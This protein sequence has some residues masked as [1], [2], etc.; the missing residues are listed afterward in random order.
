MYTGV[1]SG[2]GIAQ[3]LAVLNQMTILPAVIAGSDFFSIGNG[4]SLPI[5]QGGSVSYRYGEMNVETVRKAFSA[6]PIDDE[7]AGEN[8]VATMAMSAAYPDGMNPGMDMDANE[9]LHSPAALI[10]FAGATGAILAAVG[11]IAARRQIY[12]FIAAVLDALPKREIDVEHVKKVVEEGKDNPGARLSR[13]KGVG[14][15]STGFSLPPPPK[16]NVG[17]GRGVKF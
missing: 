7:G 2:V 12:S 14:E 1:S 13:P 16:N 4:V 8:V 6:I 15:V 9:L 3:P 10:G 11:I 5:D 17:A